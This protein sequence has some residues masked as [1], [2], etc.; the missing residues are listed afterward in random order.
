MGGCPSDPQP[1]LCSS[2]PLSF[3]PSAF[4]HLKGDRGWMGVGELL[5]PPPAKFK[6]TGQVFRFHSTGTERR[7][8]GESA[9]PEIG[10]ALHSGLLPPSS[11]LSAFCPAAPLCRVQVLWPKGEITVLLSFARSR[12]IRGAEGRYFCLRMSGLLGCVPGDCWPQTPLVLECLGHLIPLVEDQEPHP[13]SMSTE[14]TP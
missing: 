12:V 11:L 8:E 6:F 10:P 7:G 13:L 1:K 2:T 9:R 4:L 14:G 3:S 5:P